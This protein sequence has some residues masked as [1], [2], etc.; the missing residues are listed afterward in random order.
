MKSYEKTIRGGIHLLREN[1]S[2]TLDALLALP[3]TPLFW[4]GFGGWG[5]SLLHKSVVFTVLFALFGLTLFIVGIFGEAK[6]E[7]GAARALSG[8]PLSHRIAARQA[9]RRTAPLLLLK[10]VTIALAVGPI[11]VL[12]L[13]FGGGRAGSLVSVAIAFW[14]ALVYW[15]D[16]YASRFVVLSEQGPLEALRS[17]WSLLLDT[18]KET[19]QLSL[20]LNLLNWIALALLGLSMGLVFALL[21]GSYMALT[22]GVPFL[23]IVAWW[24][25]WSVVTSGSWTIRFLQLRRTRHTVELPDGTK[26]FA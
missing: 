13:A 26:L 11:S 12:S 18:V 4:M 17:A 10:L 3:A 9:L 7:T 15:L 5:V 2:L 22:I 1:K 21:E 14:G 6:L 25:A 16:L 20:A 23:F 24:L 19:F 8:E